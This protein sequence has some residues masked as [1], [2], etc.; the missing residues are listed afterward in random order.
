MVL[1]SERFEMRMDEATLAR[2]DEWRADQPDLPS[3]AEAMRRLIEIGLRK[4][5]KEEVRFTDG[6][7]VLL[8]MM[9]DLYKHL[10]LSQG[11]IDPEFLAQVIWGG[12]YWAAEWE[13]SGVFHG[14]VDER[15]HLEFVLDVL[16]MWDYMERGYDR[17]SKKGKTTLEKNAAPL[18]R[19]VRFPGF[20]GNHESTYLGITGF[21]IKK[22]NR[23]SRFAG[24]HL[25][26]HMPT[27]E[28]YK[29]MLTV[30]KGIERR[31]IG[32]ELNVEQLTA[33]LQAQVHPDAREPL[34][35]AER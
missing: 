23:F 30:F 2:V 17:L 26:S 5:I 18:G 21:L 16:T 12:H 25:N 10:D 22:L 9:R 34:K 31:L 29:R 13:L 19:N 15:Q 6:E 20:D 28:A 1:K 27:L 3:R 8:L 35:L 14:H 4:R 32:D 11:E 24:R 33:L 7:K